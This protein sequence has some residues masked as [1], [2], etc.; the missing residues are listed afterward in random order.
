MTIRHWLLSA[1]LLVL[2]TPGQAV[3]IKDVADVQGVRSNQLIGY[4]LV[5][6]LPGTGE[7]STFTEQS[8]KTMLSN[9]GITMPSNA[10]LRMN[11]V[12]AVAV[13]ADLPAFMKPGQEI[14]V[15]VSSIGS[16]S[17]LRG[18]TLLQTF[19]KGVDGKVYALAQ[20]NLVVSGF[21]AGGVDGSSILSDIPTVGRIPSGAS[22]ERAVP[23]PF[24]QGDHLTLNLQRPDFSSAEKMAEAINDLLGP[25]TANPI[26]AASVRVMAPRDTSQRVSYLST[27][28]N[29][30]FQP[31]D[32]SAQIVVNSRTGTV[33]IGK[34]VTLLP[35]AITH[36]GLTVTIAENN[37]VSQPAPFESN[38]QTVVTTQSV[39]NVNQE[40]SH[41]FVFN[42]GTTLDDLVRAI[43]A[44]G[45]GPSDIMAILDA[46]KEAGALRGKLVII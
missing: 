42:P 21:T 6:G 13:H 10:R 14:D 45:V 16:A 25:G 2:A 33:V 18:G 26:D 5:V 40:N 9:F 20:G 1:L 31:D 24:G 11:N 41:M 3:R 29:I 22:V 12:A 39:V 7:Q 32:E 44:I 30:Q 4:G 46:L 37:Q 28:E 15:T 34:D 43:N 17:S 35:A 27:I 38:G 19:L 36:G 23:T 8:F